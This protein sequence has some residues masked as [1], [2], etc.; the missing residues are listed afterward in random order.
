L[1]SR[2]VLQPV[3]SEIPTLLLSGEF[4]PIT[5]PVFATRVGENLDHDQSVAF[6]SGTHGQAFE[7]ACANQIIQRFLDN[8][9]TPVEVSCAAVPASH[10]L[11]PGDLI[12]IPP[13]REA[14]AMGAQAG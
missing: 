6:P 11:T 10:F 2:D 5:P 8:P 3:K 12:V 9:G 7:G 14:A 4:D 13:L 1:L